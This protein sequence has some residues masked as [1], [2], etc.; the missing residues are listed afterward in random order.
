M[1]FLEG[2]Y[3]LISYGRFNSKDRVVVIINNS[4]EERTVDLPVWRLGAIDVSR[5]ARLMITT[6]EGFSNEAKV[7]NLENGILHITCPPVS[8]IVVKDLS[9]QM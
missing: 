4:Q 2:Q 9:N 5:M 8:G 7:Y 3:N 1:A 6:R